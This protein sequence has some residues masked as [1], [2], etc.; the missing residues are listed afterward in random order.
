MN[1]DSIKTLLLPDGG[2]VKYG[3]INGNET[4]VFIKA[5][6]GGSYLGHE[7]KYLCIAH[8]LHKKNGCT[9]ICASNPTKDSFEKAD[10]EVIRET[11]S[12]AEG[13]AKLYYIGA[14]NG[15][16]QGLTAAAKL[17]DFKRLLLINMPLMINFHKTKAA[18]AAVKADV[19]FVYGEK[20]PSH[21]Y[22][23]FLQNA[24]ERTAIGRASIDTVQGAD[25][26]FTDMTDSFIALG[27]KLFA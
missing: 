27:R 23:P 14:S 4:I 1:F 5:G 19:I 3:I 13:K 22:V 7:N 17:F 15:A 2:T 11:I 20:D 16:V 25:H 18:L 6:A 24:I 26:N 10:A 12:A 8:M 21:P 9:V